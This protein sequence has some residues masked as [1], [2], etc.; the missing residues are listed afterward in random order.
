M[1]T[2]VAIRMPFSGV[3][4]IE[5]F[6]SPEPSFPSLTQGPKME[7]LQ[8]LSPGLNFQWRMKI[9][10]E[11]PRSANP[12]IDLSFE[13]ETEDFKRDFVFQGLGPWAKNTLPFLSIMHSLILS[14][15]FLGYFVA[16][17]VFA[18]DLVG[19]QGQT[20]L[21]Y[22][23]DIVRSKKLQNK[24]SPNFSNCNESSRIL[25]RKGSDFSPKKLRG[26]YVLCLLGNNFETSY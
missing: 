3:L 7:Q 13:S 11:P 1:A 5:S 9:S 14:N 12:K 4:G 24:G 22:S 17:A 23:K 21:G 19:S 18:E 8:G 15:E 20:T 16:I 10:S 25:H 2:R 26:F 6:S